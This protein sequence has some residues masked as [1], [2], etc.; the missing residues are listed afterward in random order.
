ML[1]Q[2]AWCLAVVFLV[3]AS[4]AWHARLA[5]DGAFAQLVAEDARIV[6]IATITGP[7]PAASHEGS[8]GPAAAAASQP[9]P[10]QPREPP[11]PMRIRIEQAG[12]PAEAGENPRTAVRVEAFFF[13]RVEGNAAIGAR[14]QLE[15][16]ARLPA[17][18]GTPLVFAEETATVLA[19]PGP[20]PGWAH[21]MRSRLAEAA[22]QLP[23]P[24][25]RLLPGLAVG[26]TQAVGEQLEEAMRVTSLAHLMAVSGANCA[27]VVGGVLLL[28]RALRAPRLIRLSAAG[29][30]LAAF[31]LLVTPEGSVI[32]A[33]TMAAIVLAAEAMGRRAHGVP[34][35]LLAITIVIAADPGMARDI[36]FALSVLATA[37]L[38]VLAPPLTERLARFLPH[39]LAAAIAVP[40]AAQ[41][42]CQPLLLALHPGLPLYGVL[43]NLLAAPLAP[44]ATALGLVACLMLPIASWAA[45]PFMLA[46]WL[47][48]QWI[49]VLATGLAAWPGATLA[50]WPGAPG[51]IVFALL[52]GIACAA[53][54]ARSRRVRLPAVIILCIALA[55]G[56]GAVAGTEIRRA[57][58][59]PSSWRVAA[60]DVGQGDASL[61]RAGGA[62]AL[63]D[64]GQDVAALESCLDELGIEAIDLLLLSHFDRDHSGAVIAIAS[65]I[66]SLIVPDTREARDER[67][68]DRLRGAGI[69]VHHAAAGDA[70]HLGDTAWRALWPRREAGGPSSAAG[71]DGSLVVRVD[72]APGCVQLCLSLLALGDLG[73]QA[74]ETLRARPAAPLEADIVKV[75][76]HGSRDQ[77]AALYGVIGAQ[78]G[79]VSVG[80]GNSYGHPAR[81]ALDALA[82]AG[83]FVART[84]WLG[85]IVVHE[86]AGGLAIWTTARAPPGAGSGDRRQAWRQCAAR[87]RAVAR[88]RFR[89]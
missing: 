80:A 50:W 46:A 88:R 17:S 31:V 60:C 5:S 43:A 79:L 61:V 14:I 7:V 3:A 48:A 44:I 74:Q 65:R 9:D 22:Q 26:D 58:D 73:A 30:A 15:G 10:W 28:G 34:L 82:G 56:A 36:G 59:A 77:D 63:I 51:I 89:S 69:P 12:H 23:P 18:R 32:R 13:G 87:A 86:A 29:A 57:G 16:R 38:L 53:L 83:T 19:A 42:S 35:L 33:G 39:W 81:E 66:G 64:A 1:P 24:G 40:A 71:N 62:I 25:G 75:S 52:A 67:T 6:A 41:L 49:G 68:L 27:I 70:W 8:G 85:T 21:G 37:G 55:V 54:L 20:L 72:P 4:G 2:L 47:A 78:L 11:R 45:L 84:D 76:H